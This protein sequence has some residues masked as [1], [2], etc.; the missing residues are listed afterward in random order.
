MSF[1]EVKVKTFG[2]LGAGDWASS[3]ARV[4]AGQ[5]TAL[6]FQALTCATVMGRESKAIRS[7]EMMIELASSWKSKLQ[8]IVIGT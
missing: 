1:M 3:W 2:A 8:I 6:H 5:V 4:G 7:A